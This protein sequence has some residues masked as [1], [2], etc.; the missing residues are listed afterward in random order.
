MSVV[1]AP[2]LGDATEADVRGAMWRLAAK[3]ALVED[4]AQDRRGAAQHRDRIVA[5]LDDLDRTLDRLE[6]QRTQASERVATL[7]GRHAGTFRE[8]V[9]AARADALR[10]PP[11]LARAASIRTSCLHCHGED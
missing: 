11:D 6:A 5:L 10:E 7:V 2:E 9:A 1:S 3:S 8:D 4:L